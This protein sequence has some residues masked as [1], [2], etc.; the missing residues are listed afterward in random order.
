[1]A[2]PEPVRVVVADDHDAQRALVEAFL[3][4]LP[5]VAVVATC[6]DGLEVVQAA[7]SS[8]A[9]IAVL[10][11]NMPRLDGLAAAELL[12]ASRRDCHPILLTSAAQEPEV[13]ARAA[14]LDVP[15][16]DKLA[17]DELPRLVLGIADTLDHHRPHTPIDALILA[18][19]LAHDGE[20]ALAV[21]ANREVAYYNRHAARATGMPYPP[22]A[23]PLELSAVARL[24]VYADGG[25]RPLETLPVALALTERRPNVDEICFASGAG[26]RRL[27]CRALPLFDVVGGTLLGSAA[28]WREAA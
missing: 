10:D 6:A 19:L 27:T 23:S 24:A 5:N 2:A 7:L 4:L 16:V 21:R 22:P 12:L 25:P 17:W 1:M 3:A 15:L 8:D 28:Y 26:V 18:A 14:E 9:D 11:V 20:A 13:V